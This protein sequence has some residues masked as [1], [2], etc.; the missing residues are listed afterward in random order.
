MFSPCGTL[1]C[2]LMSSI[3]NNCARGL[4]R[5]LI[6]RLRPIVELFLFFYMVRCDD[7]WCKIDGMRIAENIK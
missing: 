3:F 5:T 6:S 1:R 7:Y 4:E 2:V